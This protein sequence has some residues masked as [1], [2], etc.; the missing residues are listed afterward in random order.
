[1]RY[2]H[3]HHLLLRLFVSVT[4]LFFLQGCSEDSK[5]EQVEEKQ[6]KKIDFDQQI[7]PTLKEWLAEEKERKGIKDSKWKGYDYHIRI[8]AYFLKENKSKDIIDSIFTKLKQGGNEVKIKELSSYLMG[9]VKASVWQLSVNFVVETD[10]DE[11]MIKQTRYIYKVV[12]E[13]EGVID[14]IGYG[15]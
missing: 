9:T 11:K 4:I 3:F 7:L 2:R 12:Y 14:S 6:A 10:A 5:K 13:N 1:M 15:M 8:Q